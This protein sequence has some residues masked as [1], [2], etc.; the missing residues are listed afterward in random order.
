MQEA[1]KRGPI[2]METFFERAVDKSKKM[3][4][5]LEQYTRSTGRMET[6]AVARNYSRFAD[7]LELI[8]IE[9]GR[10]IPTGQ[11]LFLARLNPKSD[12]F[13][14]S[15]DERMAFFFHIWPKLSGLRE[16]VSAFNPSGT[17]STK[18]LRTK[19]QDEHLAETYSEWLVDLGLAKPTGKTRGT[20]YL[21]DEGRSIGRI[22]D[23]AMASSVYA[24]LVLSAPVSVGLSLS[25]NI[26]WELVN[27][28]S[29]ALSPEVRRGFD[30]SII[31]ALPVLMLMQLEIVKRH[32]LF[33][34][35]EHLL[36]LCK[37]SLRE[38][39]ATFKW[40]PLYRNGYIRFKRLG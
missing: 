4:A 17:T 6:V 1:L 21:L 38:Y 40:D 26:I 37:K 35:I 31:S 15:P 14:L 23:P 19:L 2:D 32:H 33:F 7:S 34:S 25:S 22:Q 16:L 39:G 9:S 24:G 8:K 30:R 28:S 27:S 29:E 10:I 36:D 11:T 20:F 18:V 5:A 13:V 12:S 3:H